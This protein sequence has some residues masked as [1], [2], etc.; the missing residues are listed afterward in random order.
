[1]GMA[2]AIAQNGKE[3]RKLMY[4]FMRFLLVIFRPVCAFAIHATIR[5][6]AIQSIFGLERSLKI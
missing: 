5:L 4:Y 3:Q 2:S 1:M 6:A